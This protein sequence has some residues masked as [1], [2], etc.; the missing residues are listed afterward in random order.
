MVA[1]LFAATALMAVPT[2]AMAQSPS[3]FQGDLDP[4]NDSGAS[5]TATVMLNGQ[6]ATVEITSSGL[7]DGSP[8]AQHIHDLETGMSECPT[9]DA[10][11]NGDGLISTPEGQPS[12]GPIHVSLTTEGDVSADSALAIE[13]F[14][15]TGEMDYSRTFTL[16][17][18][19]SVDSLGDEF[20]I[21]QHGVDVNDSGQYDGDAMSELDPELPLEATLPATCGVITMTQMGAM[22]EG[23]VAT[24]GGGTADQGPVAALLAF[25][26]GVIVMGGGLA[27]RS[28]RGNV[29][30]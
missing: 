30:Q 11:G 28:R 24:G 22:P 2:A 1:A 23:G 9:L 18:G 16:P 26:L 7:L 6:E 5:G 12:Y 4:L 10:D 19:V 25:G 21:V 14:P 17:E 29:G 27:V 3:T 15:T 13:R 20:A 8:H